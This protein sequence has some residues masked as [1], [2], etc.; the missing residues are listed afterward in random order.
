MH[1][2]TKT[3]NML[4]FDLG[5]VFL[6]DTRQIW[7]CFELYLKIIDTFL[8]DNASYS[9]LSKELKHSIQI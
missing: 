8:K 3:Q 5:A 1:K 7:A 2:H 9:K 4:N 6:R